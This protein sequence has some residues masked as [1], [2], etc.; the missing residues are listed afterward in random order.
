[1]GKK[2]QDLRKSA[3]ETVESAV[4]SVRDK[5]QQV[6]ETVEQRVED[7][8]ETVKEKAQEVQGFVEENVLSKIKDEGEEGEAAG[9]AAEDVAAA[10]ADADDLTALNGLGAKFAERLAAEGVTTFQQLAELSDEQL[11]EIDGKIKS[12][13]AR[14]QRY[15]WREQAAGIPAPATQRLYVA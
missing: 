5:A 12:F 15:E 6:K 3:K 8:T 4:T 7:I 13:A 9:E 1:M 10:G 11:Q 2:A 14:Y